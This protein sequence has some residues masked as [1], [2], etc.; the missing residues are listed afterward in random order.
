MA[1]VENVIIIGSGPGYAALY[2]ARA[3]SR[4]R[5]RGL[6]AGRPLQQTKRRE[7]PGYPQG[8]MGPQMMRDL[9]DQAE[10]FG[11]PFITE[12]DR[13]RP[14]RRGERTPSGSTTS[15]TEHA[16]SSRDGR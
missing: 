6:A 7:L 8:I 9:R 14:G 3:T 1:N 16:R 10:R 15:P 12:S 13:D 4:P 11:A 2:T 5:D